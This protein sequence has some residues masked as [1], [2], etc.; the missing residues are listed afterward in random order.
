MYKLL[1]ITLL[2]QML[3]ALQVRATLS[4][5]ATICLYWYVVTIAYIY[6]ITTHNC[7][8]DVQE[9]DDSSNEEIMY[10]F[11]HIPPNLLNPKGCYIMVVLT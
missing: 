10:V 11:K 2:T 1:Q 5:S 7:I 3:H 8:P 9:D 4:L 6:L